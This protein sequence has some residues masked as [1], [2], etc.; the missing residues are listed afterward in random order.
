MCSRTPM[1][2]KSVVGEAGGAERVYVPAAC[3]LYSQLPFLRTYTTLRKRRG[4]GRPSFRSSRSIMTTA[5]P[6]A[7]SARWS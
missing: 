5:T 3:A 6:A 7:T 1:T 2:S 4:G